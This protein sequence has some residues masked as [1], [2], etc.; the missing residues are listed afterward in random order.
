MENNNDKD[1]Q[2]QLDEVYSDHKESPQEYEIPEDI[3]E[4][5][6][7]SLYEKMRKSQET[8]EKYIAAQNKLWGIKD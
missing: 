7:K 1:I 5:T 6:L 2:D 3:L 4:K 8:T